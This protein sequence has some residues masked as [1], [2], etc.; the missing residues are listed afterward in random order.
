MNR[1]G[2][3][4]AAL[5][6]AAFVLAEAVVWLAWLALMLICGPRSLRTFRDFN[7]KLPWLT[8]QFMAGSMWLT[9][10]W[11]VLIPVIPCLLAATGVVDFLLR[12]EERTRSVAWL[13]TVL[14]LL[15]PMAVLLISGL[16]LYL[17]MIKL[18][19]GLSR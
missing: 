14:M 16:A 7:M 15:L 18:Q 5:Y 19:E 13:W 6:T 1:A 8:E 17:P 4:R 9:H 3:A 10:Y 2:N 12:R 11:Y